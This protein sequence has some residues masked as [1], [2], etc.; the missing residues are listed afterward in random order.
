MAGDLRQA[1]AIE[2]DQCRNLLLRALDKED[3]DRLAPHLIPVSPPGYDVLARPGEEI[4][5]AY[6]IESGI[7]T[8][9]ELL[10][11]GS[12]IGIAHVGYDGMAGWPVLLGSTN[13][14][15]EARI[16]NAGGT[17]FCIDARELAQACEERIGLRNT[18]LRFVR[19]LFVQLGRTITSSLTQP[20]E[21]RLCRWTLMAHDRIDGDKILVTHEEIAVMLAVR[22]ATITDL[23]H[24]LEGEGLIRSERGKVVVLD[25]PGLLQRAGD[26]YGYYEAEYSRLIARFPAQDRA[27]ASLS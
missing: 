17:T 6:F 27:R 15:H 12:R 14:P 26:D 1:N 16:T 22:R 5:K 25:R 3:F 19:A 7:V 23:L 20:V 9:S 10:S 11:D 4:R 13:A 18:L 24:T 21:T 8:F 2:Q